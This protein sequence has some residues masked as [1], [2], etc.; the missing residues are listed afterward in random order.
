MLKT[1]IFFILIRPLLCGVLLIAST[2]TGFSQNQKPGNA[3]YWVSYTGDNKLSGRF[4]IHSE[5]QTR[6]LGM[7][8]AIEQTLI[9]VGLNY[10]ID[11]LVMASAGYGYF[12]T[13]PAKSDVAGFITSEHRTHQQLLTRH[14]TR[15]IFMEHRYR[16]E[17]RFIEN[18]TNG[19]HTFDNRIR[20]RFQ[21]IL[22]F[23]SISPHLRH[24]FAAG[25]NELFL[26]LGR[27]V[28]GQIFDRNRLYGGLG[29]QVSPK[30]NF[31]VGY[32]NQL[33]SVPGI[34]EPE[35]NHSIVVSVSFNMDDI[36]NTFFKK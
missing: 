15:A 3:G 24:F 33:I 8:R 11:P 35:V 28:S 20:Y 34:D 21:V 29:Y 36:M 6:N 2:Q 30:L 25:S 16:L 18:I 4:G 17:Q 31:Q 26:N 10:Y 7:S 1:H 23:Y 32:L 9:R 12:Y 27:K 13:A 5:F 19:K 14:K 22:P